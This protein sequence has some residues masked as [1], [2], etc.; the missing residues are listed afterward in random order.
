MYVS[1]C[2]RLCGK[3]NANI[4]ADIQETINAN[5]NANINANKTMM[6]IDAQ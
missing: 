5:V 6:Y 3:N 2:E 1:C 4:N